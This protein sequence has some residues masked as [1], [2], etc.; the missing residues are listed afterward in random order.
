M[1]SLIKK[2]DALVL[3]NAS[4]MKNAVFFKDM[5][6][7]CDA[8]GKIMETDRD[9][10]PNYMVDA[11]G[12]FL[13]DGI[14]LFMRLYSSEFGFESL[15][16]SLDYL[17]V[18]YYSVATY[19]DKYGNVEKKSIEVEMAEYKKTVVTA[20]ADAR[21][22]TAEAEKEYQVKFKQ[23][24]VL[25]SKHSRKIVGA[26]LF[27]IFYIVFLLSAFIVAMLPVYLYT[28][29]K[30]KLSVTIIISLSILIGGLGFAVLF[31]FLSKFYTTASNDM[32]YLV[33]S[34]KREKESEFSKYR[35]EKGKLN[36]LVSEK[37]EY[38][39]YFSR[40]LSK[41]VKPMKFADIVEHS[42]GYRLVSYNMMYDITRLFKSFK[43]QGDEMVAK[44]AAVKK[45]EN[46]IKELSKIY[47]EIQ[48]QD[49]LFFSNNI[50]FAF[51]KKFIECAE[52]LH[53]WKI[54]DGGKKGN[55]F[56]IYAKALAKE[57]IAYLES[58]NKLFVSTSLNK[59]LGTKYIKSLN[60]FEIKNKEKVEDLKDVK[61]EYIEHFFDY[62][63]LKIYT[64]LFYD[65]KMIS[66]VKI[67]NDIIDK[68]S[69]IPTFV[70]M[71]I[72]RLE[73]MVGL[74]NADSFAIKRIAS[75]FGK[76]EIED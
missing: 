46:S 7:F 30:I 76:F 62:D 67:E 60:E 33:N 2:E 17:K 10:L 47:E 48:P 45:G 72:K 64:N 43:K 38:Q 70:Q 74:E 50:R 16:L 37:Y 26:S 75:S 44:I 34:Y 32:A 57:D 3:Q 51:L 5:L 42:K 58:P 71:K 14:C 15:K 23:H 18:L 21:E 19:A 61:I 4:I 6:A 29:D 25:S 22:K 27:N 63:K 13:L 59:F 53:E 35:A 12:T 31:K 52:E 68:H 54:D 28:N 40:T 49:N 56:G 8:Y 36:R 41:Y 11:N 39:H 65:K 66:G 55:P 1:F 9:E 69:K 24:K 73:S 20:I